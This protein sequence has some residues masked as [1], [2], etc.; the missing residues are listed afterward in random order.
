MT[1]QKIIIWGLPLHSHTHSYIHDSFFH[2][3]KS[4]EYDA[5]WI[6]DTQ[7]HV[8]NSFLDNA[9][10]IVCGMDCST[11]PINN[12]AFYVLHN[13]DDAKFKQHDNWM[14]LQVYTKDALLKERKTERLAAFTY[15]QPNERCLY[16]PWATDLLPS[17]MI[18]EPV[19]APEINKDIIWVGSVTDGMQGNIN[20]LQAYAQEAMK[21]LNIN[22]SV[23]RGIS[24][25]DSI[26]TLRASRHAPTIVGQWQCDHHYVPCRM[27]KNIS[28]GQPTFSNSE[29]IKEVSG[30]KFFE[31]DCAKLA[32]K[33]EEYLK[34]RDFDLERHII[35]IVRTEHTYVNRSQRILDIVEGIKK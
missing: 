24:K 5:H 14:K 10:V 6:T 20:Q 13:T 19:P 4:M 35:N 25:Q 31:P 21:L 9:I 26:K 3:F 34:N 11:L 12:T 18:Y 1:K 17:E 22:V 23:S 30:D 2:A 8:D 15:W 28:Y 29:V 27:F 7:A 33:T 16:Q 32:S